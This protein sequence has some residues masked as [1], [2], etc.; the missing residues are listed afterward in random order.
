[1]QSGDEFVKYIFDGTIRASRRKGGRRIK[2][3]IQ[4]RLS[5]VYFFLKRFFNIL[6][7]ILKNVNDN[8]YDMYVKKIL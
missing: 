6:P 7:K 1:M 4:K 3:E 8:Y 2:T 5:A